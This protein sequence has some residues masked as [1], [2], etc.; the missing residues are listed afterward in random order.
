LN[1]NFI[2]EGLRLNISGDD[3]DGGI[4][5][6]DRLNITI[7]VLKV[8]IKEIEDK[9]RKLRVRKST[10]REGDLT[11]YDLNVRLNTLEVSYGNYV[12]NVTGHFERYTEKNSLIW[13]HIGEI[14]DELKHLSTGRLSIEEYNSLILLLT[15]VPG[16]ENQMIGILE[17]LYR[18]ES[19]IDG[20]GKTMIINGKSIEDI[21]IELNKIGG[22]DGLQMLITRINKLDIY[23]GDIVNRVNSFDGSIKLM[24]EELCDIRIKDLEEKVEYIRTHLSD[25]IGDITTTTIS[26]TAEMT[27]VNVSLQSQK[28][29]YLT[30]IMKVNDIEI[31]LDALLRRGFNEGTTVQ[32][33][34]G[35]DDDRLDEL[36]RQLN[37]L[38]IDYY[39]FKGECL[40]Q[41][42]S[43]SIE[44]DT[45]ASK[46][47]LE[48]LRIH[49]IA[50]I[51]GLEKLL[52]RNKNDLK[53]AKKMLD[54]KV[55]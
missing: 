12:E 3:G 16:H 55:S 37:A 21:W 43:I 9:L 4:A 49:L 24:I 34:G 5:H 50:R 2:L 31:K 18:A 52:D 40:V 32:A 51:E 35:M 47:D 27:I 33:S 22:S 42:S 38:S 36:K 8:T 41:F 26:L 20:Y 6:L 11:I 39:K 19:N 44:L 23:I 28:N 45:K 48:N 25:K 14:K 54:V 10:T 1:V 13:Q 15:T 7:L 29:D 46:I 30:L 17:R 53:K